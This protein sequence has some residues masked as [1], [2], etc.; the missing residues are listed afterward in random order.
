MLHPTFHLLSA[1]LLVAPA[2]AEKPPKVELKLSLSK[3]EIVQFEPIVLT[4]AVR[5]LSKEPEQIHLKFDPIAQYLRIFVTSELGKTKRIKPD[6][7]SNVYVGPHEFGPKDVIRY[8][9]MLSGKPHDWMDTPGEYKL[10]ITF[11]CLK[12]AKRLESESVKLT[13]KA[14]E[15]VDKEALDRFRGYPQATFLDRGST[16]EAIAGQFRFITQKYPKSVYT[17]WCYYI[18]GW[19]MQN[20]RA[21]FASDSLQAEAAIDYYERLLREYPKFPM[22]TEVEY[23]IARESL[24]AAAKDDEARMGAI[25]QIEHLARKHPDLW[26]LRRFSYALKSSL[27]AGKIPEADELPPHCGL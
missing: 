10:H 25:D 6:I 15:G 22:K 18:L 7:I 16:A 9:L 3:S 19:A 5:N 14:A 1:I 11:D 2:Q 17:P 24:R 23:E 20:R 8:R 26:L 13:I 4:I 12:D 21:D 27:K